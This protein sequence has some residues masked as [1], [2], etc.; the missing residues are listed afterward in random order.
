MKRQGTK[1][2]IK[3]RI[4]RGDEVIFVAGKEYNRYDSEGNRNPYRGRVIAVDPNTGRVKVDG[5]M[6]VKKHRKAVPQMNITGGIIR[7]E[8]WVDISNVAVVDPETGD[9]TRVRYEE[10]EGAKVRVAKSGAVIPEPGAFA[11]VESS[12][13]ADESSEEA[14]EEASEEQSEETEGTVADDD[15]GEESESDEAEDKE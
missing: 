14:S 4:K 7:K 10:R 2:A 6:I 12:L 11:T 15:A 9:P 13:D 1:G 3:S 8:A 5:A